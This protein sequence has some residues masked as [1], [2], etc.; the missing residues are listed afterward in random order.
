[1]ASPSETETLPWPRQAEDGTELGIDLKVRA[2]EV[3]K[4]ILARYARKARQRG[5]EPL[6]FLQLVYV[7]ILHK[8]RQGCAFDPRRA[9]LSTYVDRV[10]SSALWNATRSARRDAMSRRRD[11]D[12]THD[13][14]GALLDEDAADHAER[15]E[16]RDELVAGLDDIDRSEI[17][18]H[19]EKLAEVVLREPAEVVAQRQLG[20]F[21]T[22]APPPPARP[23]VRKARRGAEPT[24][25]RSLFG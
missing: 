10:A 25:P 8:N 17:A 20:L 22:T 7:Q 12:E 19:P 6:D 9:R 13:P 15:V 24:Q 14:V 5:W 4:L 1:M 18:A 3:R 23:T 21:A 2:L 16:A 11:Q